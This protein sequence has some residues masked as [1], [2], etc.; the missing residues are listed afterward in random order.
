MPQDK[1]WLLAVHPEVTRSVYEWAI[2]YPGLFASEDG[3]RRRAHFAAMFGI[4]CSPP[5]STMDQ[6]LVASKFLMVFALLDDMADADFDVFHQFLTGAGSNR[7]GEPPSP[8]YRFY[9]SFLESLASAAGNTRDFEAA[10]GQECNGVRSKRTSEPSSFEEF[11]RV[12]A[13]TVAVVP[14]VKMWVAMMGIRFSTEQEQLLEELQLLQTVTEIVYLS[15]DLG[16]LDREEQEGDLNA[17]VFLTKR[18][19]RQAAIEAVIGL[20][21]SKLNDYWSHRTSLMERASRDQ[22]A[23]VF[24]PFLELLDVNITGN[25]ATM[26]LLTGRYSD[27]GKV[28]VRM[29]SYD[30]LVCSV[31]GM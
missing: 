1:D 4:L 5:N 30:G 26:K 6:R 9:A 28:L 3:Y 2:G 15:N 25:L 29:R 19:T 24:V 22:A 11:Q 8:A 17:I 27:R 13:E 10:F 18:G 20:H 16:S 31:H 23:G 7:S 12:R 14:Y 21:D